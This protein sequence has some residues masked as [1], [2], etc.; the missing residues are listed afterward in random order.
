MWVDAGLSAKDSARVGFDLP[1]VS[2]LYPV[3]FVVTADGTISDIASGPTKRLMGQA[4]RNRAA[5]MPTVQNV[6]R[7]GFDPELVRK[8]LRDPI[9]RAAHVVA[10]VRS[11]SKGSY[12][13]LNVDYESLGH[14]DREAFTAFAAELAVGLKEAGKLLSICLPARTAAEPK[15][16]GARFADWRALARVADEI[17]IM[18]YDYSAAST[19]PGPVAPLGWVLAAVRYALGFVAPGKLRVALPLYGYDWGPVGKATVV[20]QRELGDWS[21]RKGFTWSTGDVCGSVGGFAVGVC[22]KA[23]YRG[24]LS[25]M[26]ET[27]A[28]PP[29][30]TLEKAR[31]L[32]ELGVLR[33]ALWRAAYAPKGLLEGLVSL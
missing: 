31:A 20:P 33:I 16:D 24:S 9:A 19:A 18:A 30:A 17:V 25:E 26:R 4:L 29:G 2:T 14:A 23:G 15:W 21:G 8:R 1:H 11:V 28:D 27:Y 6:T 32:Q 10:L 12:R 5:L 3:M 13:G 22:A 7:A